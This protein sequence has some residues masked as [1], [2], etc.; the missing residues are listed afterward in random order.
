MWQ[1]GGNE[2]AVNKPAELIEIC[3][4]FG[5]A[6]SHNANLLATDEFCVVTVGMI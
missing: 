5:E 1:L 6:N 3:T 2:F 4:F